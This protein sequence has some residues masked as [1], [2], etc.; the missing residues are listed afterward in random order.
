MKKLITILCLFCTACSGQKEY[1]VID[2]PTIHPQLP[3]SLSA[4]QI[5]ILPVENNG[6]S[7]FTINKEN[8]ILLNKY[9]IDVAE[10]V[11]KQKAIICFYRKGLQEGYCFDKKF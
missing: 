3:P 8:F 10:Y 11:E 4:P 6:I 2:E 5:E 9:L 7:Y 1:L